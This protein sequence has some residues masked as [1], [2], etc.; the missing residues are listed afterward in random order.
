[1]CPA[2]LAKLLGNRGRALLTFEDKGFSVEAFLATHLAGLSEKAIDNARQDLG[3]L[4]AT[5]NEEVCLCV[6]G[7]GACR[8]GLDAVCETPTLTLHVSDSVPASLGLQSAALPCA[9]PNPYVL[10]LLQ[11]ESVVQQHHQRFLQACSGVEALEAQVRGGGCRQGM[12]GLA[13]VDGVH[14]TAEATM[15]EL[16]GTRNAS[17]PRGDD[18]GG[19]ECHTCC[20]CCCRR[21]LCCATT[22]M[23]CQR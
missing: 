11:V 10:L 17:A 23:A 2:E 13:G 15:P 4:L 19:D 20:C 8:A 3:A 6:C 21:W 16:S 9:V 5:C 18:C 14:F 12:T 1:V 7:G 22:P